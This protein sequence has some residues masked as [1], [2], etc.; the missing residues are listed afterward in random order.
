MKQATALKVFFDL[1][2]SV[3]REIGDTFVC[4]DERGEYLKD[5]LLVSLDEMPAQ[6]KKRSVKKKEG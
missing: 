6:K 2:E 1:Q 5:L 3:S 4:D